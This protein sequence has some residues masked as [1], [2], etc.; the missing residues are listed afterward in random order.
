[1]KSTEY[2][3]EINNLNEEMKEL[4]ERR[5]WLV[6]KMREARAAEEEARKDFSWIKDAPSGT[7]LAIDVRYHRG[8]QEFTF[9]FF[10]HDQRWYGTGGLVFS[11]EAEF[12]EWVKAR[13]A[14][15]RVRASRLE[16]FDEMVD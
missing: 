4:R 12:V 2:Q 11:G 15:T 9:M 8:G 7:V 14:I 13:H 16:L 3:D 1:M 5:A 6:R 10:K